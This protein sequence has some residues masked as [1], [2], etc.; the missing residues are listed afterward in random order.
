MSRQNILQVVVPAA[1]YYSEPHNPGS[2]E[3]EAL[4]GEKLTL[5]GERGEYF[6]AQSSLY[7]TP[8]FVHRKDVDIRYV[9][10][11]HR[12]SVPYANV[13]HRPN[14]RSGVASMLC[15]NA[16]VH[17]VG[18]ATSPEGEMLQ[19]EGLGWT[20]SEHLIRNPHFLK[21]FVEVARARIGPLPYTWGGRFN[22]D[23]SGLV[24][25][26]LLACGI[27]CPRNTSEQVEEFGEP[28]DFVSDFSNLQRGDLIFWKRHVVI[29]TDAL[30]CV[31]ST[32]A[33]PYRGV[34]EQKL[35]EVIHEQERDGNGGP[36]AVRRLPHYRS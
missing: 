4:F 1:G 35:I 7:K 25:D 17:V 32:I 15:L 18:G 3:T 22:P 6:E 31:H 28:V 12:V 29:M 13:Y 34:V 36:T 5:L 19:V 11:T 24:M 27:L 2:L 9:Q 30:R 20:F 33:P 23:C 8:G 16:Q 21:D 14:F 10:P 26:A